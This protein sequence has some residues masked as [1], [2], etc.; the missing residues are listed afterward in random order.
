MEKH[1]GGLSKA[2]SPHKPWKLVWFAGFLK[3]KDA[4][5]FEQYLKSGSGKAFSYKRLVC[6]FRE[7]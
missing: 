3:K 2:T 5:D 6:S 4:K 1:N 7:R